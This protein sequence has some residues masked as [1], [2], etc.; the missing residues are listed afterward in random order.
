MRS[1]VTF[2]ARR[3]R[4]GLDGLVAMLL[5]VGAFGLY[6]AT[7]APTVLRSDSGEFH[8]IPWIL[9]I[10][11]AP[12]YPLL[13]LLGRL[14][15][16]LPIG[17][18]A[19]RINLL[20]ALAAA[21][22]V[23]CVY[24]AV[25]ELNGPHER[26]RWPARAGGLAAAAALGLGATY[27]QQAL[28]GGPRPFVFFFNALVLWLLFRWGNRRGDLDLALLAGAAGLGLTHHPNLLLLFPALAIYLLG[29]DA[30]LL[31]RPKSIAVG[32][33]AGV[34]PLALYLYLPLRSAQEPS[35]GPSNLTDPRELLNYISAR[36]YQD[37]V[38]SNCTGDRLLQAQRYLVFLMLQFGPL[39]PLLSLAGAAVL[40][41]RA[42]TAGLALVYAFLSDAVFGICSTLAM[43]DYIVPSYIVAA[44]W[45]GLGVSRP[46]AWMARWSPLRLAPTALVI[47][48]VAGGSAYRL[49][50]GL[51]FQ[52]MAHRTTDFER[53]LSG[54]SQLA[55]TSVLIADWEA[56]TPIWYLQQVLGVNR[57][58]STHLLTA[59]PGSDAW[60]IA[61]E[62]RLRE[63]R[64]VTL[65]ER[66]PAL[67]SAYR[68]FPIGSFF[69]VAPNR[70]TEKGSPG[71]MTQDRVLR[72]LG[73][74][75]DRTVAEPGELL[76]LTLYERENRV[77]DEVYLPVLR[78]GTDPPVEFRLDADLRYPTNT[79]ANQE[80]VGEVLQLSVPLW[81]APGQLP[82]QIAFRPAGE[83]RLIG[84]E[85]GDPW[86]TIGTV[87]VRSSSQ[88]LPGGSAG[89]L[90][91]FASQFV[92]RGGRVS[93]DGVSVDL[94]GSLAGLP[95]QRGGTLEVEV[96]WMGLRWMDE[97]YTLFVHLLNAQHRLVAQQEGLPLGGIYHTYKWVP[98]QVI[99][100]W[101]RLPLASDLPPGDYWLEIGAYQSMTIQRLPVL[102]PDGGSDRS[103]LLVGP[104][105]LE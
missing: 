31:L 29:R 13:T 95:L 49:V 75:L 74:H 70:P 40:L 57:Q 34:L 14:A 36:N 21:A 84:L 98:G 7:L 10:A 53:A 64:P 66:V 99:T 18:P 91:N 39:L 93:S 58:T 43:P 46:L 60:L 25:I 24:L 62:Q 56:I 78:L 6:V 17:D 82:L 83:E 51:P 71:L 87:E 105:H 61:V 103:S 20:D 23:G 8:V 32:L 104:L 19:Y 27:W 30:R 97:S 52:S 94:T 15:M 77:K 38:L 4:P 50:T 67:G 96:H 69:E 80:V 73:Y 3:V 16:L 100:D 45:L 35:L 41:V 11:H 2:S 26:A 48:L 65:A 101:Y 68:L 63:D 76:H 9:G 59:T 89:A 37:G 72:V 42:P 47:G 44:I 79:W 85:G 33:L 1:S 5:G 81:A 55:P 12:G 22:A 86:T 88:P 92:L 28:V 102:N 54:F 90:A